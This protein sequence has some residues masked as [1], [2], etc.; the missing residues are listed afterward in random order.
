MVSFDDLGE[1]DAVIG[2]K[3]RTEI[4]ENLIN[5]IRAADPANRLQTRVLGVIV[6]L[7]VLKKSTPSGIIVV[8]FFV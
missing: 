6:A 5:C 2:V 3:L 8:T 4:V 1:E 7:K